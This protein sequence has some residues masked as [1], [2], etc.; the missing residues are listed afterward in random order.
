LWHE[1]VSA[2]LFAAKTDA[3]PTAARAVQP[4]NAALFGPAIGVALLAGVAAAVG[5]LRKRIGTAACATGRQATARPESPEAGSAV[6][7]LMLIIGITAW[8][9]F[10]HLEGRFAI[11][12]LVPAV[13]VLARTWSRLRTPAARLCGVLALLVLVTVNLG[14]TIRL[15]RN[16]GA[17]DA[18]DLRDLDRTDGLA[19][20]TAGEWPWQAHVPRLNALADEG[21]KILMVGDAR[22]F[23]L[24]RG[25]DY[26]V[27]FNRSPFAEA[28]ARLPADGLLDWLRGRGYGY[29][30]VDWIEMRRLRTSRYG[31]WP[32]VDEALFR[33]LLDAGLVRVQDF[34]FPE[35]SRVYGTLFAVPPVQTSPR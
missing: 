21:A 3:E 7:W 14:T 10:T 17:L 11:V 35:E 31:F 12:L 29:V 24:H 5:R 22:R 34:T 33:R 13:I 28:A 9:G 8:L 1:V 16:A 30:Y 23:Y 27:V 2:G 32:S 20:F 26:C 4:S 25:V 15:F 18:S 19:W 6:C